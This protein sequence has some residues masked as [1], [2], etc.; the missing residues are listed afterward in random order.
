ME[1]AGKV[2]QV[3]DIASGQSANGGQWRRQDF[4]L[5]VPGQYPRKICITIFGDRIEQ[6]NVK[7]GEDVVV[8]ADVE[9][10]EYNG[11]WFTSVKAWK[12]TKSGAGFND[13]IQDVQYN[14]IPQSSMQSNSDMDLYNNEDDLPF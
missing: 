9:S 6:F 10:R 13:N 5:E 12:I 14:D 4:I 7:A 1:F 8:D 3:L 11:R 2:I